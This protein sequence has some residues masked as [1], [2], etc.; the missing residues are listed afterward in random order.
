MPTI[1]HKIDAYINWG[2]G[3]GVIKITNNR[4]AALFRLRL[5]CLIN[6]FGPV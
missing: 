6:N 4:A 2:G 3:G 1:S 5:S